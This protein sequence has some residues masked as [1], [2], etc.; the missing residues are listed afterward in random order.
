M[1]LRLS[2]LFESQI[3]TVISNW[4]SARRRANK[5]KSRG[6]S[7]S[8]NK[9]T[10]SERTRSTGRRGNLIRNT[11]RIRSSEESSQNDDDDDDENNEQPRGTQRSGRIGQTRNAGGTI[12]AST[13]SSNRVTSSSSHR[14]TNALEN[15]QT[16]A[17]RS[18]R[19]KNAKSE[20]DQ[21]EDEEDAEE[22]PISSNSEEDDDVDDSTSEDSVS[23]NSASDNSEESYSPEKDR[24]GSRGR[25]RHRHH[26]KSG[27]KI[28][29]LPN[30]TKR[31]RRNLE[32]E[33][34][35]DFDLIRN[36][37][38]KKSGRKGRKPKTESQR[39][40]TTVSHI[41]ES[42]QDT[43]SN[44]PK[45]KG[46]PPKNPRMDDGP[47]TSSAANA[48]MLQ[49]P[50]R[51]T[52]NQLVLQTGAGGVGVGRRATENDHSYHLPVRNGRIIESDTDSREVAA[53]PTRASVK[54]AIL[55]WARG[56]DI[57]DDEGTEEAEEVSDVYFYVNIYSCNKCCFCFINFF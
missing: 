25:K 37:N 40:G 4:K 12:V 6:A 51:N 43:V 39:I 9:R 49:S 8:P 50:S 7:N 26:H 13:S 2:A 3:K 16:G 20:L 18:S 53:R 32:D 55:E 14:R 5:N 23:D 46:R 15:S 38:H 27:R 33:T 41:D 47:S 48:L 29:Q 28:K 36:K 44:T 57:E 54:R 30:G 24:K 10:P 34:D 45:K 22:T 1:T 19:R 42:T 21:G 52:R 31:R 17:S 56:S 11:R 35:E